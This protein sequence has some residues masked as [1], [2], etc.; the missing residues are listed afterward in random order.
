MVVLKVTCHR[1]AG[2]PPL[3]VWASAARGCQLNGRLGVLSIRRDQ[4]AHGQL[5]VGIDHGLD[6]LPRVFVSECSMGLG[7][8]ES[9]PAIEQVLNIKE[10][11]AVVWLRPESDRVAFA[12][13][14][15]PGPKVGQATFGVLGELGKGKLV[16]HL[17]LFRPVTALFDSTHF[18]PKRAE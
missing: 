6:S 2:F 12:A 16:A 1:D 10:V 18:L 13:K 3:K 8:E 9:D 17:G 14:I 5:C 15:K 11:V 7:P 4:L